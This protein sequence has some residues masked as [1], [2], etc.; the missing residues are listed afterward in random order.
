MEK[1]FCFQIFHQ[2]S[3]L[4]LKKNTDAA[5]KPTK[6]SKAETSYVEKGKELVNKDYQNDPLQE[7]LIEGGVLTGGDWTASRR[8]KQMRNSW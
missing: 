7:E 2:D 5:P 8:S 6:V 3:Y 1:F 4:L